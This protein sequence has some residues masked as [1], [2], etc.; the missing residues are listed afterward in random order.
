M[1]LSKKISRFPFASW[2][3]AA[4]FGLYQITQSGVISDTW[5][6]LRSWRENPAKVGAILPSGPAL[7]TAITREIDPAHA[8]ILE[9]GCGT[10]VF[11]Q[12]IVERGIPVKEL[13]LVETDPFFAGNLQAK[14]P[15]AQILCIDA[16]CIYLMPIHLERTIGAVVCGLPL[17]NMSVKQQFRILRGA[18]ESLRENG[19]LYLFSYGWRCPLSS[20]LLTRLGLGADLLDTVLLNVPP[21]KV[22]KIIRRKEVEPGF[23]SNHSD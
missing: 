16:C 18:F 11:T 13:V 22:W 8:P 4:R 19:A 1:S 17:R 7:S 10:G 20:P 12:K 14:F 9:L 15:Q 23:K 21:A 5:L 3:E 2:A 6:F